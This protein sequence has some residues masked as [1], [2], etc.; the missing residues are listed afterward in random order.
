MKAMILAAG[1]GTRMRPLTDHTPKPLLVADDRPLIV[2]HIERLA[3][4]G[5]RKLVI[6]HA[7]LGEQ[8]EQA[9]G[10][11][12][13]F[14]V[15]IRYSPEETAL[16]TGGGIRRALPLLGD[17]PFLVVN[18]DVW[19]DLEPGALRLTPGDLAQ[20]AL[21]DNPLHH[22]EGD[23]VLDHGRV[24]TTG[25][26]RLTFAGIGLYHPALFADQ[27]EGA[28]RLAP[29]LRAAMAADRVGGLHHRGRWFDIGTP[30]R[31]AALDVL[32]RASH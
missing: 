25:A 27:P 20:L 23:F 29:L 13:R 6:N 3:T 9:L 22:P 18:G 32:L 15:E 16:E 5:V 31:L 17:D 4:A 2:H 21:V 30:E 12:H 19:C 24:R 14:G 28:F 1:R 10:D 26:P 8:I 11:G 7:H